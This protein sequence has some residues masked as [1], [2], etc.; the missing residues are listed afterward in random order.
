MDKQDIMR[1]IVCGN[2]KW[3]FLFAARDRM[4]GLPG[5]FS[6]YRC[7]NCGFVRLQPKLS[8]AEVTKYY[9]P[10]RYYSYGAAASPSFFGLLRAFFIAH[11]YF[12][13][14]P[15]MPMRGQRGKIL[16][17]GCGSGDTLAQLQSIGWDVYGLDVDAQAIG[18]AHQ[19]GLINI[20]LGSYEV[21]QKYPDNF[22]DAIRLYHVIEHLD[23]PQR[24][25]KLIYKKLK[26][27]GEIIIGTPN[28]GS[29]IAKLAK[30]YWLNLDAPRHLFLFTPKTL[31]ILFTVSG[32]LKQQ[33][34][35]C[36]AGGWV[37]SIQYVIEEFL[38][39]KVNLINRPWLVVLFYPWEWILD[40][41]GMGDV[42]V[43]RAEK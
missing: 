14:V 35:F 42:F 25:V 17:V 11:E 9:P 23:D 43:L 39:K 37:G 28:A 32:F 15:A 29:L 31:R 36:S 26:P 34:S 38:H 30:Q 40:R 27:G 24:C 6:E 41:M 8:K 18:V 10:T 20:S 2:K 21:M 12:F 7:T 16:D 3:I 1:C 19:R 4:F 22:F 5:R 13:F 33:V